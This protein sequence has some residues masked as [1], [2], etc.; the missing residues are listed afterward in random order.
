MKNFTFL[1]EAI[2]IIKLS[3]N[4]KN[5]FI[6][7]L[8]KFLSK[9]KNYKKNWEKPLNEFLLHYNLDY[10]FTKSDKW[11]EIDNKKDYLKAKKS[12]R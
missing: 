3:D 5:K 8:Q 9:K 7:I 1:G 2:G 10:E 6:K 4:Y 11:I 12:F